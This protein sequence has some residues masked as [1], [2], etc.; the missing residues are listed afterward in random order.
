MILGRQERLVVTSSESE[1]AREV[2]LT[3]DATERGHIGYCSCVSS[4]LEPIALTLIH[5]I[6]NLKLLFVKTYKSKSIHNL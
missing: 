1:Q 6:D 4:Y 2:A 3:A 5:H